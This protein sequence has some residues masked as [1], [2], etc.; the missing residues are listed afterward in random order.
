MVEFIDKSVVKTGTSLKRTPAEAPA[1]IKLKQAIN[2][3][4][5]T[6]LSKLGERATSTVWKAKQ[7]SLNRIVA[8]RILKNQFSS[9]QQDVDDFINEAKSVAK[10]K[11]PNIIQIYDIGR[12]KNTIYFV[13]EYIEGQT[14]NHLLKTER[15]LPQKK[16]LSIA[17]AVA[18]ALDEA[19]NKGEIVHRDINPE[20]IMIENDGSIKVANLGLAGIIDR[21][22]AT[23]DSKNGFLG[24]PNYMSPE[25]LD[26]TEKIN[27]HS[28]MYS[29]GATLYHMLTG[30]IPFAGKSLSDTISAHKFDQLTCP[31]DLKPNITTGC[32]QIITRL[33]AKKP[34]YRFKTW[35]SAYHNL[36]KLSEGKVVVTKIASSAISTIAKP[37]KVATPVQSSRPLAVARKEKNADNSNRKKELK[38]KY[39]KKQAPVWLRIPLELMMLAW[40]GWLGYQLIWLP[41]KLSLPQ[42]LKTNTQVEL[43]I[44]QPNQVT[45]IKKVQDSPPATIPIRR[46]KN[47]TSITAVAP[48]PQTEPAID[49]KPNAPIVVDKFRSSRP[50]PELKKDIINLLIKNKIIDAESLLKESYPNGN[51]SAEVS[52]LSDLLA[53][54]NLKGNAVANA[55]KANLGKKITIIYKGRKKTVIV[56]S[57]VGQSI[58]ADLCTMI[59]SSEKITPIKFK[60]SDLDP[61]EQSRQLGKENTPDIAVAKYLLCMN[62]GD[63]INARS[64]A[65]S[66]GILSDACGAAV[67][68]KIK[69]IME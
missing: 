48:P 29:L 18:N 52:E 10:L 56:K 8:I 14:L 22:T 67:D 66:C 47:R 63:Y 64:L 16:A 26:G 19:W 12:H 38:K 58:S 7:E 34:D 2:I 24:T 20:N 60:I 1:P 4:G 37:G 6:I 62:A 32:R 51:E 42:E 3:K 68:A 17:A 57:V 49:N 45:D 59:G 33:M 53:S 69:M 61:Q 23:S 46:N 65:K 39:S 31:S 41:I 35:T 13:M 50:L 36:V 15:Y 54:P 30:Q 40:F 27:Y 43:D 28:D 21:H 5:Y 55:F 9:N 11:S 44:N 25:L